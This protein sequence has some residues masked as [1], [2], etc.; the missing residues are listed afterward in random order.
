[1]VGEGSRVAGVA[2]C[3][4]LSRL[5]RS[6]GFVCLL[7]CFGKSV[8]PLG[9]L[10]GGLSFP[11]LIGLLSMLCRTYSSGRMVELVCGV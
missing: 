10:Q 1:M 2:F 7:G 9:V 5:R 4:V 8:Y 3:C 6:R 11:L